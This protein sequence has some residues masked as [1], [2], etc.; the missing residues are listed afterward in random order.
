MDTLFVI[1]LGQKIDIDTDIDIG[2]VEL[3]LNFMVGDHKI[4][5]NNKKCSCTLGTYVQRFIQTYTF[6]TIFIN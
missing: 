3:P 6:K 5:V 2:Y 4:F 1:G